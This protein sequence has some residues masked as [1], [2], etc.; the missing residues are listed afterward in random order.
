[1]ENLIHILQVVIALGLLNVWLIRASKS[2][3]YRGGEAGSMR[4]EFKVYGLPDCVMYLVGGLKIIIALAMIA[5]IW[6]PLLVLP[7]SVLLII[8]M[9]GAFIMHLK[10]KDPM[11]K[12]IP[13]I[14]MLVLGI[15]VGVLSQS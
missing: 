15:A 3:P 8:L 10:V 1:M 14:I 11:M 2:T 5:G 7:S 6:F 12:A 13:S 9:V 4:E